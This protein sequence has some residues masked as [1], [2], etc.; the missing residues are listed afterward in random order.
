MELDQNDVLEQLCVASAYPH[1]TGAIRRIETHISWVYLTGDFAY[2]IKKAVK[3][4]YLDFSTLV[5]RERACRDELSLNRRL[6][7]ALY[8][9]V[10][11]IGGDPK[12]VRVGATPAFEFAV[13]ITEFPEGAIADELVQRGALSAADLSAFGDHIAAFHQSLAASPAQ[14]TG[15]RILTN[16]AE[17]EAESSADRQRQ[18]GTIGDWIRS[19]I[20]RL[21]DCLTAR[22]RDGRIRECHGDLHLGNI[23]RIDDRLIAFDCLEFSLALRT[24]DV[25]DEV[26]FL[27][28][29]LLAHGRPDLAFAFLNPYLAAT[30]DYQG[31]RLLRLYAAHR[32]LVRAKVLPAKQSSRY[33]D[34][35][36]ALTQDAAPLCLI[37][38]GFSGSGKTTIARSLALAL[39]AVHL[40]SDVERKRLNKLQPTERP[41]AGIEQGL[42]SRESSESTYRRLCESTEAALNGGINVIVDASFLARRERDRFRSLAMKRDAR[43][44]VLNLK[45]PHEL[46][47]RRI[48]ERNRQNSDA[49]DA[50]LAVLDHQLATADAL[51]GDEDSAIVTVATEGSLDTDRLADAIRARGN[52]VSLSSTSS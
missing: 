28:M 52:Q 26:A 12:S 11:G 29:D 51:A 23:V 50:D 19:S 49:S 7:P 45:A 14:A 38:H 43:F 1:S 3:L 21:A 48:T 40:R 8:H 5:A 4:P 22:T 35:A 20:G 27:F 34:T 37:T 25:L 46:L 47:R 39:E 30:G 31:L 10:V 15:E 44:A 24:I 18:L 32:A 16:L 33:L 17:V 41:N 13:K 2:K 6:A 42:Y 9:E 36:S